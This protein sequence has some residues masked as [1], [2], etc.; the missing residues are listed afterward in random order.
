MG[1]LIVHHGGRVTEH[2]LSDAPV[3]IGRD[4]RCDLFFADRKLSRQ[5]ARIEKDG[6]RF[7]LVDLA[8]RNGSWVNEERVEE[9]RLQPGDDIRLGGVRISFERSVP[10][11][12]DRVE[13]ATAYLPSASSADDSATVMLEAPIEARTDETVALDLAMAEQATL[14]PDDTGT[15]MLTGAATRSGDLHADNTVERPASPETTVVLSGESKR[16]LHD[17][18]KMLLRAKADPELIA[19]TRVHVSSEAAETSGGNDPGEATTF[20]APLASETGVVVP[21][22]K[23]PSWSLR[24]ALLAASMAVLAFL[25][26]ALPLM[27]TLGNALVEESQLR[28]RALLDV[29]AAANEAALGQARLQDVSVSR[30]VHE[31]G[32]IAAYV[33]D[34]EGALVAPPDDAGGPLRLGGVEVD[35]TRLSRL[36]EPEAADGDYVVAKPIAYRGRPVGV[37]VLRYRLPRGGSS[38]T[39]LVLVLGS[40]LMALGVGAAVLVARRI[41]LSPLKELSED[42]AAL[43]DGRA[44]MVSEERPYGELA[45]LARNLNDVLQNRSEASGESPEAPSVSGGNRSG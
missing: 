1:K 9:R 23:A 12:A 14:G 22:A 19:R 2:G 13:E 25:L 37:A 28:G 40:L 17:T 27:R 29:L 32:V 36:L 39:S 42:V 7:R 15:V 44:S 41:T 10:V 34:A 18:G 35:F 21:S 4:P 33:V 43:R 45:E 5:H 6:A 31:T 16:M 3:V 20:Y 26:L 11:G 30:V 8:S 24:F 38:W